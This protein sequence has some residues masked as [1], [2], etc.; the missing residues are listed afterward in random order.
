MCIRDSDIADLQ[1]EHKYDGGQNH[2][3]VDIQNPLKP[4]SAVYRGCFI[5]IRADRT[6]VAHI[7]DASYGR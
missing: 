4:G 6:K 2:G 5:I 1:D 7:P 3:N